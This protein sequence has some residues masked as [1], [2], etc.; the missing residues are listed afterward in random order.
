MNLTKLTST[1]VETVAGRPTVWA[2][3]AAG[4]IE[5]RCDWPQLDFH[6]AEYC[7]LSELNQLRVGEKEFA[8]W[9]GR[10]FSAQY[11]AAVG[12]TERCPQG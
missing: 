6:A 7:S 10:R 2:S 4:G 8:A 5:F 9:L 11:F 1:L 12:G 3:T